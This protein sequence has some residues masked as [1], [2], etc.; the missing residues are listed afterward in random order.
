MAVAC[1]VTGDGFP[2]VVQPEAGAP[3]P[4]PPSPTGMPPVTGMA[5]APVQTA[6]PGTPDAAVMIP[7]ARQPATPPGAAPAPSPPDAAAPPAMP[8]PAPPPP[9][10]AAPPAMPAPAPRIVRVH[11]VMGMRI[12]ATVVFAHK[13]D[14]KDANVGT[15]SDPLSDADL[16]A[17][18][19]R[20]DL[21]QDAIEADV[22]YAHD[23]KVQ[24]AEIGTAHV[25]M[26]KGK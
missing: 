16:E 12:R 6:M 24:S 20:D 11:D 19:G 14:A 8:A 21:K 9:D 23:I 2:Y 5:P 26:M 10:A 7:D 3:A 1:T 17:Q 25:S 13:L 15:W 18:I 22:L 4:V